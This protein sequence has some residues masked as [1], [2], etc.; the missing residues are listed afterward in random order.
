MSAFN[1]GRPGEETE[2]ELDSI[3]TSIQGEGLSTGIP[4]TFIRLWGCN[5]SCSYCDTP[6]DGEPFITSP[7]DIVFSVNKIR[8]T[9]PNICITG[10]EPFH[11]PKQLYALITTILSSIPDAKIYLETNGTSTH[12]LVPLILK[13]VDYVTFSPKMGVQWEQYFVDAADEARC[14]IVY[15]TDLEMFDRGLDILGYKG[16]R[17]ASPVDVD[18]EK[19]SLHFC[20]EWIELHPEWRLSV[21]VHKLLGIL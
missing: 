8:G 21:Q 2:I 1:I 20:L 4:M 18:K 17:L 15:G 3:F 16:P 5:L 7:R 10:G 6:Q 9:N 13:M 19:V 12:P 11:Q 14:P